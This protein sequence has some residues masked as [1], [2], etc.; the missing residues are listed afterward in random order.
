MTPRQKK[1]GLKIMKGWLP[2][3]FSPIHLFCKSV[4]ALGGVGCAG[5]DK[6]GFHVIG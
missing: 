2:P 4:E 5:L 3:P 6:Q 1:N